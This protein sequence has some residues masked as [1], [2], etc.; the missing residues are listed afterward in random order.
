MKRQKCKYCGKYISWERDKHGT[1]KAVEGNIYY[2]PDPTGS[3][4]VLT[5]SGDIVRAVYDI[6][7]DKVGAVLH[8]PRCTA[9]PKYIRS[10]GYGRGARM[11][12]TGSH[13]ERLTT[14]VREEDLMVK[15]VPE[16]VQTSL[17]D[18]M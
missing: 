2:K 3:L 1:L 5:G 9:A 18:L 6:K 17:F 10:G 12:A 8:A 4:F 16:A 7:S 13:I 11:K 15:T 14:P